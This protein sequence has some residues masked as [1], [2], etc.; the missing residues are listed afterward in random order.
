MRRFGKL[1]T[2]LLSSLRKRASRRSTDNQGRD[3][4]SEFSDSASGSS[5][6]P[7]PQQLHWSEARR[8]Y[9]EPASREVKVDSGSSEDT[10]SVSSSNLV[11]P[12]RVKKGLEKKR[13][14]RG[15]Q[16]MTGLGKKR[17]GVTTT[18][19]TTKTCSSSGGSR[20]DYEFPCPYGAES[21]G[22]DDDV[23]L[24]SWEEMIAGSTSAAKGQ[25][26][27]QDYCNKLCVQCVQ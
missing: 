17:P 8:I 12:A 14:Y 4:S 21:D 26:K 2:R 1:R 5:N 19:R 7:S 13:S 11:V 23:F 22:E 18:P 25:C 27:W 24:E 20:E 16:N 6:Q 10:V 3:V 15:G 9:S